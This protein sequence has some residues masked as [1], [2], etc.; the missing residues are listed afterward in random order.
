MAVE[1]LFVDPRRLDKLEI[2]RSGHRE[3]S[4]RLTFDCFEARLRGDR[5][6]CSKGHNLMIISKSGSMYAYAVL[7]GRTAKICR[8]CEDFN[9]E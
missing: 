4:G 7:R 5:V 8:E 2:E 9:D 6:Y 1:D 3:R